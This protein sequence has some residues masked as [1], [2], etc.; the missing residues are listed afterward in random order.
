MSEHPRKGG[1]GS[2]GYC[3][4]VHVAH[5]GSNVWAAHVTRDFHVGSDAGEAVQLTPGSGT[6][7]MCVACGEQWKDRGK[8]MLTL[9]KP[10]EAGRSPYL[11]FTTDSGKILL[12]AALYKGLMLKEVLL[13]L[14]LSSSC[15]RSTSSSSSASSSHSPPSFASPS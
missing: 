3:D 11:V 15:C 10:E 12:T 7:D 6:S 1:Y 14:L 13:L 8:G 9:R 4:V 5:M 2:G